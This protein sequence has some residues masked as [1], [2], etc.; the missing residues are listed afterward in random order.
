M[1]QARRNDLFAKVGCAGPRV[2]DVYEVEAGGGMIVG[3]AK[4]GLMYEKVVAERKA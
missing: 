1:G 4:R 2:G 3:R